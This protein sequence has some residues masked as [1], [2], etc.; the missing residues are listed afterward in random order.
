MTQTYRPVWTNG[1]RGD[2]PRFEVGMRA[3]LA[4]AGVTGELVGERQRTPRMRACGRELLIRID[5]VPEH[6]P[7]AGL[8]SWVRE[9]ALREERRPR[10]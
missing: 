3:Y 5:D 2:R 4:A 9:E 7:I 8:T 1:A 10:P 6:A